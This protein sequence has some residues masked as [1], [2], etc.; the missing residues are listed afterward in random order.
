MISVI[1]RRKGW[2]GHS[3]VANGEIS[4]SSALWHL[5]EE[6]ALE[7]LHCL[8]REQPGLEFEARL[9]VV[10]SYVND[11]FVPELRL[12]ILSSNDQ[13]LAQ[14]LLQAFVD[15]HAYLLTEDE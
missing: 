14:Q 11:D 2:C 6:P 9:R 4:D 5:F 3:Y 13:E 15:A 1:L 8:K 7:F 10:H 12:T